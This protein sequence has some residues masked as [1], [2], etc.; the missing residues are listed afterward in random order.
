MPAVPDFLQMNAASL[1]VMPDLYNGQVP[2]EL[3]LP[4]FVSK[5]AGS[6]L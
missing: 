3:V 4:W 2:A 6:S 1:R 5:P